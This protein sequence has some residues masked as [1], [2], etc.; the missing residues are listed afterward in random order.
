MLV[1]AAAVTCL[2]LGDWQWD[3][4]HHGGGAQSLGYA[5]QWPL[6]SV[7][8]PLAWWRIMVLEKRRGEETAPEIP[9]PAPPPAPRPATREDRPVTALQAAQARRALAQEGQ[10]SEGEDDTDHE[11]LAYN[12]YLARLAELDDRS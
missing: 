4:S 5:L 3:R 10:F 12:A 6:F 8:I 7:L 1:V 2:A 11:L 9:Q